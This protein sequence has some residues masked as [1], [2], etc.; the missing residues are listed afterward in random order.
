MMRPI[1]HFLAEFRPDG[2][3]PPLPQALLP[4]DGPDPSASGSFGLSDG[5]DEPIDGAEDMVDPGLPPVTGLLEAPAEPA[6]DLEAAL[7]AHDAAHAEALEAALAEARARWA[8]EEGA[9]LA[10]HLAAAFADLETRLADALAPLLEPFLAHGARLKA[11]DQLHDALGTLFDGGE[12]RPVAVSG[13][14]DLVAALRDSFG[15]RPGASFAEAEVP[16]V[17][18]TLGDTRI[19]SQLSAWARTL[20]T[21]LGATA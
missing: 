4:L 9:T 12:T 14:A 13:P 10:G 7:A 8:T 3:A 6:P 18:V 1:G 20:D 19:R 16:D 15:D 17:T 2:A 5:D 21:A 11:L